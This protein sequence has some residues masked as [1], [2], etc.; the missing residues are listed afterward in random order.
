MKNMRLAARVRDVTITLLIIVL[1]AVVLVIPF[2]YPGLGVY[3]T[4]I[5]VG[6]SLALQKYIASFVG[7]FVIRWS[8]IFDIGDRIRIGNIKGDVKH[9]GLFHIIVDEVGDD[10]KMGGE[11]TGRLL[12]I[13]NL[14]VLDQPVLNYSKD[15]SVRDEI[16]SCGFIFDEIR[17]PVKPK[18]DVKKAVVILEELLWT[19]NSVLM[20]EAL[21]V[22]GDGLPNFLQD[23]QNGPR[24]TIHIDEERIWIKGRFVTTL[25]ARNE[26]KTRISLDF[27]NRIQGDSSIEI[28]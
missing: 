5:A 7:H 11:L 26:L 18:S 16:I 24:V 25:K 22:F 21:K 23:L 9:I 28:N 6:A 20:K 2:F 12:H 15:Y 1:I 8:S 13:P 17:I 3:I 14:V 10:E 27:I 19:E 4:I